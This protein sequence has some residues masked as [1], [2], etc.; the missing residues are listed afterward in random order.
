MRESEAKID[1][2]S[3]ADPQTTNIKK[4]KKLNELPQEPNYSIYLGSEESE[5][6]NIEEI[7]NLAAAV[8]LIKRGMMLKT[9]N[10]SSNTVR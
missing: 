6:E 5:K 7:R 1:F 2:R 10:I 4:L 9:K 3:L 8:I